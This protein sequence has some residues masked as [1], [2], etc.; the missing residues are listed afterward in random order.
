ML[1]KQAL[2]NGN[3]VLI[4]N[5]ESIQKLEDTLSSHSELREKNLCGECVFL[6]SVHEQ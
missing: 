5:K 3:D 1:K 2:G 6:D 4:L